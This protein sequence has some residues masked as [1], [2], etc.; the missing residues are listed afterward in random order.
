MGVG[1]AFQAFAEGRLADDELDTQLRSLVN[2]LVDA[3]EAGLPRRRLTAPATWAALTSTCATHDPSSVRTRP[4]SCWR[5]TVP[6]CG[7]RTRPP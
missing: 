1:S 3:V 6:T 5:S 7:T 4:G 2:N